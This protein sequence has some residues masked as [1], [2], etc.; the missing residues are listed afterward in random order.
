MS[1]KKTLNV[2]L[3]RRIQAAILREPR[4]IINEASLIAL[5]EKLR[6]RVRDRERGGQIPFDA[7]RYQEAQRQIAEHLADYLDQFICWFGDPDEDPGRLDPNDPVFADDAIWEAT[8]RLGQRDE[9][10][11]IR[12]H[13]TP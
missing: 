11:T 5:P 7:A 13:R 1:H 10:G 9:G 2:R 3:L 12:V 8:E 4:R 6:S